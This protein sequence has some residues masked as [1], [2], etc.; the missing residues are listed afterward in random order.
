MM[1]YEKRDIRARARK[2]FWCVKIGECKGKKIRSNS[3][4]RQISNLHFI[5]YHS[6][7]KKSI[8]LKASARSIL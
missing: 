7:D 8:Q 2:G 4:K 3:E 1:G 5:Y 6:F